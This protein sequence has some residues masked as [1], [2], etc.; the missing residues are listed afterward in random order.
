VHRVNDVRQIEIHTAEPSIP[1]ASPLKFEI[2]IAMLKRFKYYYYLLTAIG[3]MPGG[4]VYKRDIQLTENIAP[5]CRG[6]TT[7]TSYDMHGMSH[8]SLDIEM[9][10]LTLVSG[11]GLMNGAFLTPT[12]CVSLSKF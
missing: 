8:N 6:K 10:C 5:P 2:T 4:S 1:E 3:L 11:T 9:N 12:L 7:R